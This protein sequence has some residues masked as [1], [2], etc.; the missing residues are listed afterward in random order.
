M[1]WVDYCTSVPVYMNGSDFVRLEIVGSCLAL[2]DISVIRC[3][4]F[5]MTVSLYLRS[6]QGPDS[7]RCRV[8][9]P[10]TRQTAGDVRPRTAPGQG[11]TGTAE[12]RERLASQLS[13]GQGSAGWAE[14]VLASRSN[15][16]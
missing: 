10:G 15:V 3:V 5:V 7:R 11:G 2:L 12:G 4:S 13:P 14:P 9:L 16:S 6:P 1:G 8:L